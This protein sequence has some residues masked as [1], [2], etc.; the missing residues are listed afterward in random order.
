V[1]LVY[2]VLFVVAFSAAC[3]RTESSPK[4]SEP[5]KARDEALVRIVNAA[6][7]STSLDL[8]AGDLSLFEGVAFKSVTPYRAVDGHRYDFA[9]RPAGMARAKPLST[10][11]E[12]LDKGHYYTAIAMP[13]DDHSPNLRVVNDSVEAPAA[14]KARVRVIH[15]G[16]GAGKVDLRAAGAADPLFDDVEYQAVTDYRDVSPVDGTIEVTSHAQ[17]QPVMVSLRA[18]V[19][20]GRF[21]TIVIIGRAGEP[22][23]EG[24][25]IEDALAP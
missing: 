4:T 16:V 10:N 3:N 19:E 18:H 23:L 20:A 12:G 14:G 1:N 2:F 8:F 24:F 13:G 15:A 22:G 17:A 6:P 9:L 11:T 5:A 7:L 25:L 21:Y